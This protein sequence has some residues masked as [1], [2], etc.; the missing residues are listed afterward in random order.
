[1][2]P[3]NAQNKTINWYKENSN[4]L[5]NIVKMEQSTDCVITIETETHVY[6]VGRLGKLT[7]NIKQANF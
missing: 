4:W 3:T 2:T 5:N 6:K 7:S 1:M